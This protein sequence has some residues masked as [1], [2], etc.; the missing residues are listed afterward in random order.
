[1]RYTL[2]V[3]KS[4][5]AALSAT[6]KMVALLQLSRDPFIE[7]QNNLAAALLILSLAAARAQ[8]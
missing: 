6:E 5:I 1:L 8:Q 3:L 4:A 2:F 7:F